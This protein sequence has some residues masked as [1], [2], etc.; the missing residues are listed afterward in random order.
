ML[1]SQSTVNVIMNKEL[2]KDICDTHGRF[3]CVLCNVGTRSIRTEATLPGYRIVWFDDRCI[4][5][6]LSSSK[7]KYNYRVMYDSS[8][9]K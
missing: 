4:I 3:F 5:N 2:M 1:Y 9:G 6:I 8:E 7:A